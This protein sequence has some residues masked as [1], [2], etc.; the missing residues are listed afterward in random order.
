MNMKDGFT[1]R[2]GDLRFMERTGEFDR[3]VRDVWNDGI[4]CEVKY[5]GYDEARVCP[6]HGVVLLAKNGRVI[7]VLYTEP[8]EI[9]VEPNYLEEYLERSMNDE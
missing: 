3:S 7:T 1:T 8:L 5:H 4:P 2:H 6:E 9:T